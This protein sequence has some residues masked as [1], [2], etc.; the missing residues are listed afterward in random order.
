VTV[1]I[2]KLE[3]HFVRHRIA[4]KKEDG[5]RYVRCPHCES[6]V[7]KSKLGKHLKEIHHDPG[8]NNAFVRCPECD[9]E[10]K[11][12]GLNEHLR[13]S[14]GMKTANG[15]HP[16]AAAASRVGKFVRN[17]RDSSTLL[18]DG[19][20]ILRHDGA[21]K[22]HLKYITSIVIGLIE[23]GCIDFL[24]I[25]DANTVDV[26]SQSSAYGGNGV[27][28]SMIEL[29]PNHVCLTPRGIRADDFVL[30]EADRLGSLAVSNDRFRDYIEQYPWITDS[31][32]LHQIPFVDNRIKFAG[33]NIGIRP[34][35]LNDHLKKMKKLSRRI[36]GVHG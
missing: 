18:I 16:M 1:G 32:R 4:A 25:F 10:V 35:S 29:F 9:Q 27:F 5:V 36:Y 7:I 17:Q 31:N 28:R 6:T 24:I 19:M 12:H 2:H 34:G 26:L 23:N 13:H 8:G 33:R 21:D 22:P 15:K 11:R 20:N 14:H 3:R 30:S